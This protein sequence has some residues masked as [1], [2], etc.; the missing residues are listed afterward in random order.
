MSM[1]LWLTY[2]HLNATAPRSISWDLG[3]DLPDDEIRFIVPSIQ[4]FQTGECSDGNRLRAAAAA[5][6]A[7]HADADFPSVINLFIAEEQRHAAELA[8]Y[9]LLNGHPVRT[10][11][12]GD[13]AFRL[14]RHLTGRLEMSMSVLMVAEIIGFGYY[15]AL[16]AATRSVLLRSICDTFLLDEGAHLL[17]HTEQHSR[18]RRGGVQP[19]MWLARGL[20]WLL[21]AAA[22]GVVWVRHRSVLQRGGLTFE[23]FVRRCFE[24]LAF[25]TRED[26]GNAQLRG[27]RPDP[28]RTM[29]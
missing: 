28:V 8:R 14:L 3:A 12:A 24:R 26:H 6:G 19:M 7:R 23:G 16:R 20:S 22:C 9:L 17:F 1:R 29:N 27:G 4:E 5:W 2:F 21:M 13:S 25:I 15:G 18:M 11:T 10:R